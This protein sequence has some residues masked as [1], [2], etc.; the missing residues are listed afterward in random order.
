MPF[1]VNQYLSDTLAL[2]QTRVRYAL[3]LPDPVYQNKPKG[4]TKHWLWVLGREGG[5]K[6]NFSK[7]DIPLHNVK[8]L[9]RC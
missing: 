5:E 1:N 8:Q 6:G 4:A 3:S 2:N 9:P 7:T